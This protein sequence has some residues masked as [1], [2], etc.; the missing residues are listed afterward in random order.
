MGLCFSAL[1]ELRPCVS[2]PENRKRVVDGDDDEAP[3]TKIMGQ[4]LSS[5]EIEDLKL[6]GAAVKEVV[7][8]F[9]YYFVIYSYFILF[10]SFTY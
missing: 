7:S 2:T 6:S 8:V 5:A 3:P 1:E 10:L 9:L 4:S